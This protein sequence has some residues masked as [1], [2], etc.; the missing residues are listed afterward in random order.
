MKAE[1]LNEQLFDTLTDFFPREEMLDVYKIAL[2]DTWKN[3]TDNSRKQKAELE[4]KLKACSEQSN[5]I[6]ELLMAKQIQPDEYRVMK[7][8]LDLKFFKLQNDLETM[9]S[10]RTDINA[11]M[12]MG[13][14]NLLK[15]DYA[16]SVSDTEQQRLIIKTLFPE[17][18]SI[19]NR[20]LRTGRVNE[21]AQLIYLIN[22][23]LPPN[24]NGQITKKSDLSKSVIS[25]GFEPGTNN[26]LIREFPINSDL[27]KQPLSIY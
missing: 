11:L 13:L 1:E 15:L 21:A 6:N 7:E 26:F 8:T 5:Y 3:K 4:N 18:L 22:N 9:K 19:K 12:N 2:E 14:S 16:F 24:K 17:L 20:L 27:L 25:S 23:K 10:D